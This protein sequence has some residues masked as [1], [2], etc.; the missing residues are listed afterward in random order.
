MYCDNIENQPQIYQDINLIQSFKEIDYN[1]HYT[2]RNMKI[3]ALNK[4]EYKVFI[5]KCL[6]QL[7]ELITKS[8]DKTDKTI[9]Y[10][11]LI[12]KEPFIKSIQLSSWTESLSY[13]FKYALK[14]FLNET[15]LFGSDSTV[16]NGHIL[17]AH[18]DKMPNYKV[19][20]SF[21]YTNKRYKFTKNEFERIV[22][23]RECEETVSEKFKL[24]MID[25]K[26][27]KL[28][29][30]TITLHYFGERP[31]KHNFA[32]MLKSTPVMH[33][34]THINKFI[35]IYNR[36]VE[37]YFENFKR[38]EYTG[39]IYLG[40]FNIREW[41]GYADKY[42]TVFFNTNFIKH[43]YPNNFQYTYEKMMFRGKVIENYDCIKV[44]VEK[45]N[46]K[47]FMEGSKNKIWQKGEK[48]R[49]IDKIKVFGKN[50]RVF[51]IDS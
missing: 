5:E 51:C 34:I 4:K 33:E 47:K 11:G 28:F 27:N 48:L 2:K 45:Q 22:L 18:S 42:T 24:K 31:I 8:H 38:K 40:F 50:Y 13:A 35:N 1:N 41:D 44:Y 30:R 14:S 16:V 26:K 6:A 21:V 3:L 17:I 29:D 23:M 49:C 37:E 12:T 15:R 36:D 19:E 7:K 39:D 9:I 25:Y 32:P 43:N 20:T 46:L 10:R